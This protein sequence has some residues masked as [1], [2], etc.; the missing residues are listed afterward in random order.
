MKRKV[1]SLEQFHREQ[2]IEIGGI[3][4]Q[5]REQQSLTLAVMAERTLIR[6]ALLAALEAADL[7][8][9]PEPIYIR[10][11][12]KRYGDQ[13]DG[14]GE[15]L[16]SQF[17][18][19]P[20]Q[21]RDRPAWQKSAAAQ[22]RPLHLYGLYV[23]LLLLS[24][25][26]LSYWFK[27]NS[28][29]TTTLPNLE[30][31]LDEQVEPSARPIEDEAIAGDNTAGEGT[32]ALSPSDAQPIQVRTILRSQSW[33]RVTVDGETEFEGVLQ[34]GETK[35]WVA[36]EVLTLRVGNAGG[37]WVAYNN[38]QAE[39]MGEPGSVAEITYR[40]ENGTEDD[41]EEP[42]ADNAREGNRRLAQAGAI[43]AL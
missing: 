36:S 31:T 42:N 21:G 33:I 24:I 5:L 9:L 28:P 38:Q 14:D 15:L 10:G 13:L 39:A 41:A 43:A 22:L 17:L 25:S 6:P 37:V 35:L 4:R 34:Q 40:S 26:G 23:L 3:L 32:A 11:L 8:Q 2:L 27:R 18:T 7:E 1:R 20:S 19:H 30:Q 29:Q 12:I 16:A